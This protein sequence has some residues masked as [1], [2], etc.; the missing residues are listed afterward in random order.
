[1][2]WIDSDVEFHPD[3]VDKIRNH[4]LPICCG[5]YPKKNQRELACH[6][7]PGT[8]E[9]DFGSSGGLR[10]ILYAGTGFLLIK[11]EVFQTMDGRLSLPLCNTFTSKTIRP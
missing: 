6:V 2:M 7:L 1:M 5:I 4:H 9:I 8:T 11:R 3:D 10:E